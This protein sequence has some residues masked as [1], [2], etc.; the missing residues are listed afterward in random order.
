[1][2]K[3]AILSIMVLFSASVVMGQAQKTGKVPLKKLEGTMVSEK[4]KGNFA[5]DFPNVQNIKWKELAPTM[6]LCLQKTES[7]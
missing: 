4:A 2:K 1:M 7:K 5:V 3:F 6:R